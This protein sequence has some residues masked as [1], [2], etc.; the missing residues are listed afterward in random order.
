MEL[1]KTDFSKSNMRRQ[2]NMQDLMVQVE[3]IN[4][5]LVTTSNRVAEELGVSH[6]HL[7]EKIDSYID[8]FTKA[9][10]SALAREF[11]IPSTYKVEGNFKTYKN[12]L[13]TEKGIA[14]K[15]IEK[16]FK[17]NGGEYYIVRGV[18]EVKNI[19]M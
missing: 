4:G 6:K 11:Y 5:I 14:Q 13:I 3:N 1:M 2:Y 16:Q 15:D 8:K 9:E 18:E 19:L 12:Y 7:L 10:T 17:E